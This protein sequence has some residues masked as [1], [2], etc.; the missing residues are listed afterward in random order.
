MDIASSSMKLDLGTTVPVSIDLCGL[1][2][3]V[4]TPVIQTQYALIHV[5]P[6]CTYLAASCLSLGRDVRSMFHY[7]LSFML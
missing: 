6:Y 3:V 7:V 1:Q 2:V 5:F 4:F